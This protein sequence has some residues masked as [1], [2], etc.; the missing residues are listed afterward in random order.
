MIIYGAR[1]NCYIKTT[2]LWELQLSSC[3]CVGIPDGFSL[4]IS[5]KLQSHSFVRSVIIR[6]ELDVSAIY[7]ELQ[8]KSPNVPFSTLPLHVGLR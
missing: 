3:H 6:N 4:G 2:R 7:R 1:E 8:S 5:S